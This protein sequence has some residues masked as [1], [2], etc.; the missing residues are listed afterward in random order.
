MGQGLIC[1]GSGFSVPWVRVSCH[2][3]QG[4]PPSPPLGS[5]LSTGTRPYGV[6]VRGLVFEHKTSLGFEHRVIRVLGLWF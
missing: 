6:R 1:H 2:M 3:C 4:M 5:G